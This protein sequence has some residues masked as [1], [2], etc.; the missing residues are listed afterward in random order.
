MHRVGS[1]HSDSVTVA[2]A[3]GRRRFGHE[4][5]RTFA[6]Q[7]QSRHGA[8][9]EFRCMSQ[10]RRVR[11]LPSEQELTKKFNWWWRSVFWEKQTS[12]FVAERISCPRVK[13]QKQQ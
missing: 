6:R 2:G 9:G 11:K 12:K 3:Q 8:E 13:V 10:R 1:R 5:L 7:A 4:D